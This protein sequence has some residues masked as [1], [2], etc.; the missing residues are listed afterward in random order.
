VSGQ[1]WTKAELVKLEKLYSKKPNWKTDYVLAGELASTFHRSP[2]S[3]RWQ[4][5]EFHR[6]TVSVSPPKILLMDIETRP[7]KAWVWN[8]WDQNISMDQIIEDW[9]ILCWSAKWL[10]DKDVMGQTVTVEEAKTA[11]DF[12]VLPRIWQ[13][14]NEADVVIGHN[15]KQFDIK[16]L[17]TRFFLNNMSK[18][19]YFQQIDTKEIAKQNFAFLHNKLDW[20]AQI[21]GIGRKMET[22]FSWWTECAAGNKK[23]LDKMLEYN[24]MDGQLE[25]EVY[26]RLRPW[27]DKHPNMN[28]YSGLDF[29]VCPTCGDA[30]LNW[31]GKYATPLG[32]YRG[33]RCE[34]CG[35][36][37][38]CMKKQY[39]LASAF[40]QG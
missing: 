39:K 40:V 37:G 8:V 1:A 15:S 35:S 34:K 12:S 14:L 21:T 28:I 26:M 25:D 24:K 38:R 31:N 17:N 20:I 32:L 7:V 30:D 29:P 3:I 23:Y 27:M 18:P 9:S 5:R 22:E 19:M 2:E 4:L 13:L 6:T 16:R 36:I 11:Q 33:F 10:F